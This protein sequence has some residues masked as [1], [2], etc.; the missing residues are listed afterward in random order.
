MSWTHTFRRLRRDQSGVAAIEMAIIMPLL[1][2]MFFGM[3][4][5][6]ALLSDNRRLTYSANA[7][8]NL[9]TRLESPATM[10]QMTD[11]FEAVDLVMKSAQEQNVRVE[12]YNFRKDNNTNAVK[13]QWS[14][15]N[16][17]GTSCTA[18]TPASLL[19][20]MTAG[21]D[22]I[23]AVTCAEY[24]PIVAQF[25]KWRTLPIFGN[26]K[27]TMREQIVTRPRF[28]LLLDCSDCP[29]PQS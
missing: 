18:P 1:L 26:A 29:T 25:A 20:L 27:I 10:E 16:G 14:H 28:S 8:A 17:T 4:D 5:I 9:V 24:T 22:V 11:A 13:Q 23:I 3:I 7:V 12:I 15:N 6:T 19:N 21:N 2:I